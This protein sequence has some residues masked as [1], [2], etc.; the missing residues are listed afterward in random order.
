MRTVGVFAHRLYGAITTAH[1]MAETVPFVKPET[2]VSKSEFFGPS[3]A[4]M[5]IYGEQQPP[6]ESAGAEVYCAPS[7]TSACSGSTWSG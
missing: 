7:A 2:I 4:A 5:P 3:V 6:R 1:F